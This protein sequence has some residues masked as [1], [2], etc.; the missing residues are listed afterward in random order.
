MTAGISILVGVVFVSS[1]TATALRGDFERAVADY[2]LLPPR[3]VRP[4]ALALPSIELILGV[5]LFLGLGTPWAVPAAF[6]LFIGFSVAM[7]LNLARGRR[8]PCGCGWS[9]ATISWWAVTRNLALGALLVLAFWLNRSL[10][11]IGFVA[12]PD[13]L[14]GGIT[15]ACVVGAIN[16]SRSV[17]KLHTRVSGRPV[18]PR[19]TAIV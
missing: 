16:V 15:L 19:S 5:L 8:I 14:A 13:T 7:G 1:A 17:R 9:A 11:A 3:L 2:A 18:H 10:G 12:S 4:L 6:A